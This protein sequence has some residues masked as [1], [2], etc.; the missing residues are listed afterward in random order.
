LQ[1]D[2]SGWMVALRQC[3]AVIFESGEDGPYCK[4]IF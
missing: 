4:V 1:W 2:V 3:D